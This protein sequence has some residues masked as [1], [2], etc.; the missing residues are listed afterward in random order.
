MVTLMI[1]TYVVLILAALV[2]STLSGAMGMGG[3]IVLLTVMAQYF[4]PVVLIPLHGIVQLGSNVSRSAI[5]VKSID[6]KIA[7]LFGMGTLVG[8]GVGSQFVISIP[9]RPFRIGI[10]VFIL[11]LTFMPKFKS[12]PRFKGKWFWVGSGAGLVS[13][14]V[15]AT[16]PLIAPFYLREGLT[17]ERLVATKAICQVFT[18]LFKITTFFAL[19]F[20]LAPYLWL[21][22]S[23]L[24]AVFIGNNLGKF[25]L[26][27]MPEKVFFYLF[28]ILI[29]VLAGR[30]LIK[31]LFY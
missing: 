1:S 31:A 27:R 22:V 3:G 26:H 29:V 13:L 5:H 21:I 12:A 28:R 17:K 19:G 11:V 23:M 4:T 6:W 14:F 15:G 24:V 10:A 18:H 30:L 8:V 25:L 16:G 2:T 20:V 7:A 9:E